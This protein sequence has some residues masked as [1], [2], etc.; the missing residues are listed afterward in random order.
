[1][2]CGSLLSKS[3]PWFSGGF[4]VLCSL[5]EVVGVDAGPSHERQKKQNGIKYNSQW[6]M[7]S[8]TRGFNSE[9]ARQQ[10]WD[11]CPSYL[12]FKEAYYHEQKFGFGTYRCSRQRA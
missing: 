6:L 10:N 9:M 5:K 4:A 3:T 11:T 12:F 2:I 1:M 8:K 7:L